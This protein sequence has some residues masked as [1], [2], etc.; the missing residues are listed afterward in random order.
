[1]LVTT[2]A[3][4][5]AVG[6]QEV[7]LE[8][9]PIASEVRAVWADSNGTVWAGVRDRGLLRISEND[10]TV[11]TTA[12]GMVSDGAADIARLSDGTL[13]VAGP[14]G[15][16]RFD[17]TS[18]TAVADFNGTTTRV[19][20]SLSESVD[21]TLRFSGNGGVFTQVAD[22]WSVMSQTDGLPHQ[23]AHA[24]ATDDMGTLWILCRRGLARVGD[25][26]EVLFPED[27]HRTVVTDARQGLWIG[28]SGRGVLEIRNSQIIRHLDGQT[29]MPSMVA[30]DGS[31][32]A[33]GDGAVVH[34]YSGRW[35]SLD[36]SAELGEVELFDLAELPGGSILIGSSSG[37]YRLDLPR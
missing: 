13:W 33:V 30:S 32:W 17:G 24:S 12:D 28:T 25:S 6:V 4:L 31:I 20:F 11:F 27:N 18:W 3:I 5:S 29:V 9:T 21:G 34:R 23:V 10:T 2:L 7:Q 35:G 22:G 1:M 19:L 16:S 14:G 26:I 36:L 15:A 8:R 37:L